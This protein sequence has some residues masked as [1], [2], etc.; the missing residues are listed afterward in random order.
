[1]WCLP[2]SM[3]V[4]DCPC[5]GT[6]HTTG[7]SENIIASAGYRMRKHECPIRDL[8]VWI[9]KLGEQETVLVVQWRLDDIWRAVCW[10]RRPTRRRR[11]PTWSW[12]RLPRS[13][14]R[15]DSWTSSRGRAGHWSLP[16][17]RTLP[18]TQPDLWHAHD[19]R[20]TVHSV[21]THTIAANF[22][23][24]V[25]LKVLYR[26]HAVVAST[27]V[28]KMWRG[29]NVAHLLCYERRVCPAILPS[30][31]RWYCVKTIE[32]R[33]MRFSSNICVRRDLITYDHWSYSFNLWRRNRRNVQ[34]KAGS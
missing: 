2:R 9:S 32:R 20:T 3:C 6:G 25:E 33:I 29:Y 1:M 19:T 12:R 5:V 23:V 18:P 10:R 13:R 14:V 8:R 11:W 17:R 26:I 30:V 21:D 4:M 22:V 7:R 28:C 16:R 31:T 34:Q 15:S 27:C 24:K